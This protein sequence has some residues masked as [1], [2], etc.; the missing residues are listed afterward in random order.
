MNITANDPGIKLD[1]N[2]LNKNVPNINAIT[3]QRPVPPTMAYNPPKFENEIDLQ[4]SRNESCCPIDGLAAE[5]AGQ[6]SIVSQY[7]DHI[8]LQNAI[9]KYVGVDADR[10][11][12]TAGGDDA[13]D[14]VIANSMTD[15]RKKIVCHQ[16]SFEMIAV[17]ADMY[18]GRLDAVTWLGGEFPIDDFLSRIDSGTALV[19]VVSPNNPTGCGIPIEQILKIA[20]AA[21]AA[22]AR[23]LVDNAYIEFADS[24]PTAKLASHDNVSIVRTFSK[25]IGLAGLRVGYLIASD[26]DY[27][28]TIRNSSGPFPVSS[29]SLETA[30]RAIETYADRMKSN[31]DQIRSNRRLLEQVIA[32]CGAETLPSQGNFV[33]GKFSDAEA[34]WKRLAEQGIAVRIFPTNELLAGQLRITCPPNVGDLIRLGRSIAT[35]TDSDV[36]VIEE[37]LMPDQYAAETNSE[38]SEPVDGDFTSS[39]HRETK[40]T[41]IQIELDL[42]GTGKTEISTGIGFLDH[43]LTALAFHSGMDLKLIC[44]GDLHIDDHHTAEDCALALGTAIDEALGPRRGIKRFGFAYAPLD[45]SLARTVID[46]SGR[47]WPEVHLDLERE[48]VGTWACENIVHFFQSF[49]MTLKCSLHV[50]VIRGTNDHHKAEAAFKSLAKALQQALTRTRGAVPSTKGVL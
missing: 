31:I 12:V 28:T 36:N 16:P 26:K 32:K 10:I 15:S 35:A 37:V 4:L 27:A 30:R 3:G 46:L 33:L 24:D 9:A 48:M 17:Y 23:L 11:V 2:A 5:L 8:P 44:E 38:Q 39:T 13:I 6:A 45:E 21:K 50:D 22:G 34:V 47:P 14:R 49:A 20:D 25:A 29:V 7:P 1:S 19:T 18:D 40:E 41:N 42:Y 43:M